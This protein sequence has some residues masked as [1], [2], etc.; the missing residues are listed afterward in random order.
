MAKIHY[1]E[2]K[3][4]EVF[5]EDCPFCQSTA[6]YVIGHRRGRAVECN[7]CRAIGPE[8]TNSRAAIDLWNDR[9]PSLKEETDRWKKKYDAR[10]ES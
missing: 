5:A 6:L 2:Q 3:K 4:V 7:S 10:E 8:G 1:Y 9:F